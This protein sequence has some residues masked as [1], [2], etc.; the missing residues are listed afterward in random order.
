MGCGVKWTRGA[1]DC[2]IRPI[3]LIRPIRESFQSHPMRNVF[4]QVWTEIDPTLHVRIDRDTGEPMAEK[5][6][7]LRRVRPLGRAGVAAA[8][9][10]GSVRVTA[11]SVGRGHADALQHALAAG[12]SEAIE[13]DISSGN[14]QS[15][16]SSREPAA[17]NHAS[18]A[19]CDAVAR[20]LAE[21]DADL[22]IMDRFAG[23][24][25]GR[26][27]WA[28]LAGLDDMALRDGQLHA[29]RYVGR[30]EREIVTAKLPAV[31]RMQTESVRPP[32]VSRARIRAVS[33]DAILCQ[34]LALD[35]AQA[36]YN[37]GPL[38]PARPR[39]RQGRQTQPSSAQG[40]DRLAA[41]M[42]SPTTGQ[43][44]TLDPQA[45]APGD[46]SPEEMADEFVRYLIHHEL[47][48]TDE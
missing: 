24:V 14:G 15:A 16:G 46:K 4:V 37:V 20:W 45:S 43:P 29:T 35:A 34:R 6:D 7:V 38:Q 48:E 8:L 10:M 12:V 40:L 32:Y 33:R 5:G 23:L 2:P 30:G 18:F 39:T 27:D 1:T 41:L 42:S 19:R 13:L 22:V 11:F 21:N 28:H 36:S 3:R 26:L 44:S 31:V 9:A 25:A 17:S 47:W